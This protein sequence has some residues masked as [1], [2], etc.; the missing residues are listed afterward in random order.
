[1]QCR[2]VMLNNILAMNREKNNTLEKTY[3]GTF[4]VYAN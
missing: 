1:M 2:I 3:E 4:P